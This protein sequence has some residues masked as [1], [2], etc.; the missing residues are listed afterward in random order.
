[1]GRSCCRENRAAGDARR[2][3]AVGVV[4]PYSP[5]RPFFPY[6]FGLSRRRGADLGVSLG[7]RSRAGSEREPDSRD[8]AGLELCRSTVHCPQFC[9][10]RVVG[11]A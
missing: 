1:M 9:L 7:R 11:A 8:P 10:R 6:W 5:T 2:S 4:P 3:R